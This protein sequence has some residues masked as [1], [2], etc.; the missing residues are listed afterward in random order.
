MFK[1]GE[2]SLE[3]KDNYPEGVNSFSLLTREI[4]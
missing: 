2:A 4:G 1:T 3:D